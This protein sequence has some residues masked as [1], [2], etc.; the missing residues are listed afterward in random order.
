MKAVRKSF[1][2]SPDVRSQVGTVLHDSLTQYSKNTS[3]GGLW[4]HTLLFDAYL[5]RHPFINLKTGF[6][7]TYRYGTSNPHYYAK[8]RENEDWKQLGTEDEYNLRQHYLNLASYVTASIR[9]KSLSFSAGARMERSQSTMKQNHGKEEYKETHLDFIPRISLT[10]QPS[11]KSQVVLSYYCG[12]KR[13]SI[14]LLNPF[15]DQVDDYNSTR[16]N[17]ELKSQKS[18]SIGLNTI[19][20]GEKLFVQFST[21]YIMT[22]SPMFQRKWVNDDN[23]KLLYESYFNGD[24]FQSIVPSL[25]L[26]YQ[27]IPAIMISAFGNI[28]G[29]FFYG[30]Q[31]NLL[32]KDFIYNIQVNGDISLPQ[33][34]YIGGK[35]GFT[36][37]SPILYSVNRHSHLYSFS[38][39]SR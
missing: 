3:R 29:L 6:I 7:G 27:P 9:Y 39:L 37:S 17:P 24:K 14:W 34:Y 26:S 23:P 25:M 10:Y 21:D 36:Q 38:L 13:P 31:G 4:E 30:E 11:N 5:L 35:Y 12:V 28:G 33:E 22:M 2:F 18:H 20:I 8:D 32:Q 16:G 1:A 19:F 15:D